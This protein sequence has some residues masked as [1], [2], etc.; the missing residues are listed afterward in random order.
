LKRH[1]SIKGEH[2]HFIAPNTEGPVASG[3]IERSL[4]EQENTWK[5]V[6]RIFREPHWFIQPVCGSL[7][8]V[9]EVTVRAFVV[10]GRLLSW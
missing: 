6:E 3:R 9:G 5:V 7:V 2:V 8:H 1:H 4:K 10:E